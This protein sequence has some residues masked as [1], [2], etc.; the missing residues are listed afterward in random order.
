M[1]QNEWEEMK[2]KEKERFI[3]IYIYSYILDRVCN[4]RIITKAVRLR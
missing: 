1:E 3:D 2:I 4:R